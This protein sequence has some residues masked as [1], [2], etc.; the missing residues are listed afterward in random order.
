MSPLS[1][2]LLLCVTQPAHAYL[3]AAP[4]MHPPL[5]AVRSRPIALALSD[6]PD[7]LPPMARWS[8]RAM[9][10]I[11]RI[12]STPLDSTSRIGGLLLLAVFFREQLK[13]ATRGLFAALLLAVI[14]PA[15]LA[16]GLMLGVIMSGGAGIPL[17]ALAI[18][19]TNAT[20][21]LAE[22]GAFLRRPTFSTPRMPGR[23]TGSGAK[24]ELFSGIFTARFLRVWLLGFAINQALAISSTIIGQKCGFGL[25]STVE[26]M[27][28]YNAIVVAP[29]I[30]ELMFRLPFRIPLLAGFMG[31]SYISRAM[32]YLPEPFSVSESLRQRIRPWTLVARTGLHEKR[33]FV[34]AGPIVVTWLAFAGLAPRTAR[35]TRKRWSR[36][37]SRRAFTIWFYAIAMLFA[38]VHAGNAVSKDS[39]PLWF[40]VLKVSP[41]LVMGFVFGYIRVRCGI[42]AAI[43]M[44]ALHNGAAFGLNGIIL[45][46]L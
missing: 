37:F 38:A 1:L 31:L 30:E 12:Q 3:R 43:A 10:V 16:L 13:V 14:M 15:C 44:H 19:K 4:P 22:L 26:G 36:F 24:A 5:R 29:I 21:E 9:P 35:A 18:W 41:Q 11:Q 27:S 20:C 17:S 25:K 2:L 39:L 28:L 45:L 34:A 32:C 7:R 40:A 8:R 42:G 33:P 23:L 6:E 46:C